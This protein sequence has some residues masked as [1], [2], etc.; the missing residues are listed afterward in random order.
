MS[1]AFQFFARRRG[2]A[3]L[4]LI[5]CIAVLTTARCVPATNPTN[6]PIPFAELGVKAGAQYQGDG[7]SVQPAQNG[8]RLRCD[9]QKLEGEATAEGLWLTSTADGAKGD[10]FRIVAR[11]VGREDESA[12]GRASLS[13]CAD[14]RRED[15]GAHGVTL[16][17]KSLPH[18]GTVAV[19][20]KVA[21]FVRPGLVEEYSV[22]VDGVRQDFIIEQRPVGAGPLRVELDV[23]GANVEPLADDARL[24]RYLEQVGNAELGRLSHGAKLVLENSGRTIAYSRLRVTDA[25]GKKLAAR[26]EVM[27]SNG[28]SQ[29]DSSAQ[30]RVANLRATLG[31]AHP[32]VTTLTGL[33]RAARAGH[34]EGCDATPLGL[35]DALRGEPR[36]ARRT[37]NPGLTDAIPSGLFASTTEW[38]T[39]TGSDDRAAML[40]VVVVEDADAVYPVRIDPTFSDE[41]W[42]SMGGI[43]GADNTVFAAA[44]DGS[45]NL[46]IGGSFAIVGDVF[47]SRIAKWNGTNWTALGSG[48]NNEVRALA[49]LGSD[50]Y[51]GGEFTT[52]GGSAANAIAKWDGNSWTA[53]GSGMGG[54]F[55]SVWALAVSGSDVYAGGVFT[56]AGGSPANNIA[57]WNGSSWTALGSGMNN[58][59]RALAVLGSDV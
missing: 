2:F 52:A 16:L 41:N 29:R 22:S 53:L 39:K 36:V 12:G 34:H 13:E 30:P 7:L 28:E 56:T 9:F 54:G 59:V 21:R 35:T 49:V 23:A 38:Q 6:G 3:A 8:A 32:Q 20:E 44:V 58:E 1:G 57:K 26:M 50:V 55:T 37:R 24:V 25:T 48:M 33:R 45:G 18:T 11:S 51:A 42:T 10:R 40:A 17:T 5:I 31:Q 27:G 15:D 4:T 43:P 19:V 47:A 46:Y 14:T